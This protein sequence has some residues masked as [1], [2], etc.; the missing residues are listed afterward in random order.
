MTGDRNHLG[1]YLQNAYKMK[2]VV[3]ITHG[4]CK[5]AQGRRLQQV[6]KRQ[7]CGSCQGTHFFFCPLLCL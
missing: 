2:V 4:K 1:N 7:Q 3:T 6:Q 5:E